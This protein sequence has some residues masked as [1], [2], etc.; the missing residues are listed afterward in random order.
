MNLPHR[1]RFHNQEIETTA[2]YTS[3]MCVPCS[4]AGISFG[5]VDVVERSPFDTHRILGQK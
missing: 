4:A 2:V 3:S 5:A 1:T